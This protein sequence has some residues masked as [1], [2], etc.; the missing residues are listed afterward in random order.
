MLSARSRSLF[1][2]NEIAFSVHIRFFPL[3]LIIFILRVVLDSQLLKLLVLFL[4][5]YILIY[6]RSY[7]LV[8]FVI[9]LNLVSMLLIVIELS[10]MW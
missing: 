10:W 8:E 3:I 4:N 9:F 2:Y 1:R 6:S 7:F 5:R